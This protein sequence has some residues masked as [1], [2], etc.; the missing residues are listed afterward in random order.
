MKTKLLLFQLRRIL[1]VNLAA[2]PA[3]EVRVATLF[4]Q[5]QN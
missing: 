4:A 3:G 2:L 1:H 5:E